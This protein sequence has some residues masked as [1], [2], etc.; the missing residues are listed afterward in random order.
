MLLHKSQ[1]L[2]NFSYFNQFPVVLR[3][4]L[5]K[6]SHYSFFVH[7][8]PPPPH[9][10]YHPLSPLSIQ[11]ILKYANIADTLIV[12]TEKLQVNECI[13]QRAS[14]RGIFLRDKQDHEKEVAFTSLRRFIKSKSKRKKESLTRS[15]HL[16]TMGFC[17]CLFC[18]C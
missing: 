7:L 15:Y 2:G 6:F 5:F 13:K 3:Q 4:M 14:F 18:D 12:I 11:Y 16:F 1:Q 9:R 17:V 10:Y 8:P